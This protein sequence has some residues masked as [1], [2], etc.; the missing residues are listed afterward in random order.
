VR[1]R[2]AYNTLLESQGAISLPFTD[3]F[4]VSSHGRRNECYE[5]S[6]LLW[7]FWRTTRCAPDDSRRCCRVLPD[8]TL[9]G[10][11]WNVLDE[12]A[13]HHGCLTGKENQRIRHRNHTAPAISNDQST[14]LPFSQ[15][16]P[17][18]YL[19]QLVCNVFHLL[20]NRIPALTFLRCTL[21]IVATMY[22]YHEILVK[23]RG[24]HTKYSFNAL[25]KQGFG[26]L[27]YESSGL[28]APPWCRL[29]YQCR[30]YEVEAFNAIMGTLPQIIVSAIYVAM[31]YQLTA[32]VHLRDWTRLAT[33][34]L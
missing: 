17:L 5:A 33:R 24:D 10:I 18:G 23:F 15:S 32:M 29:I 11:G 4:V 28:L 6:L 25:R 31:N 12:R 19:P 1:R 34:K 22:L 13:R 3:S 16:W 8:G 20:S 9:R 30:A 7:H 14:I 27:A 26:N 2:T 21:V